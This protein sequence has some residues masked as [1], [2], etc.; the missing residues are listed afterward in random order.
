MKKIVASVLA[1]GVVFYAT[2]QTKP[3]VVAKPAAV[4]PAF[5]NLVDSFSYA[6][7]YN[8]AMNMKSQ[9][10][11]RINAAIM[12]KAI[13]DVYKGNPPVLTQDQMNACMQKQVDAFSKESSAAEIAKGVAFL[14]ANKKRAGVTTLPDGLQYEVLKKAESALKPGSL[15]TVVVN[16]VGTLIDGKE[17]DNS[18]KRGQPAVFKITEVIRGWTEVLQLMSPGDKWKVY[19]PTELAYYLNPR[20]PNVIPP[21]AALVFEITLEGIKPLQN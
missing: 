1:I 14:D 21:G 19:I 20:D 2:A 8:V 10:I 16:Y 15:D 7:G 5:K 3:K 17:F 13:D 11:N 12:Q 18:Y 4:K 9:K 6:A